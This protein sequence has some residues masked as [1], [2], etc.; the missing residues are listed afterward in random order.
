MSTKKPTRRTAPPARHSGTYEIRDAA[1]TSTP[2]PRIPLVPYGL[3][4]PDIAE[5]AEDLLDDFGR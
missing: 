1:E 3:G 5:R 2:A 4:A